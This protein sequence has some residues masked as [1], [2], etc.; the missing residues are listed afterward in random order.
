M[1]TLLTKIAHF[2]VCFAFCG[3]AIASNILEDHPR[4]WSGG[5][6][7]LLNRRQTSVYSPNHPFLQILPTSVSKLVMTLVK[8]PIPRLSSALGNGHNELVNLARQSN[9]PLER[10]DLAVVDV[11]HGQAAGGT[12]A[13]VTRHVWVLVGVYGY[14]REELGVSLSC[15]LEIL[16]VGFT[17]RFC[18]EQVKDQ[19]ASRLSTCNR[20]V[21]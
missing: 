9:V 15:A 17:L 10:K 16:G 11:L 14:K 5:I 20:D 1:T 12:D 4:K 3:A 6:L 2:P 18:S 19:R 8:S 13:E 21:G 7:L